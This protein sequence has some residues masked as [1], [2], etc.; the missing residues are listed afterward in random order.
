MRKNEKA[1]TAILSVLL[2]ILLVQTGLILTAV[3]EQ[4]EFGSNKGRVTAIVQRQPAVQ[5]PVTG[6]VRLE[7]I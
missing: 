5:L 6:V 7:V 3:R 4:E 1:L 2:L